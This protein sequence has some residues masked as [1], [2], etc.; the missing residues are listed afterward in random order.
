MY[1]ISNL[2]DQLHFTEAT[3]ER[4]WNEWWREKN[5]Q[6][7]QVREL[8]DQSLHSDGVPL[9]LVAHEGNVFIGTVSV[10]END[11][12]ERPQYSPWVAALWVEPAKRKSGIG[13]ALVRAATEAAFEQGVSSILVCASV[14]ISPFY[15][16]LGWSIVE[17]DV[18]GLNVL[19]LKLSY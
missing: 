19:A 1:T 18:L 17:Q 7:G 10:I 4:I 6:I 12:D 8:V 2:R 9:V 11:M 5:Y 14:E 3:T 13:S 15:E 16:R